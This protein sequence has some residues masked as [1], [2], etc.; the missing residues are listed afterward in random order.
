MFLVLGIVLLLVGSW[1]LFTWMRTRQNEAPRWLSIGRAGSEAAGWFSGAALMI[2]L[3]FGAQLVSGVVAWLLFWL[4]WLCI[5]AVGTT[6]VA[7]S[8]LEAFQ[9]FESPSFGRF[10]LCRIDTTFQRVRSI[11]QRGRRAIA[12]PG[13]KEVQ[14][15][16]L[17]L[18]R[19]ITAGSVIRGYLLGLILVPVLVAVAF[20]GAMN[21]GAVLERQVL[22]V[23]VGYNALAAV[24]W[25]TVAMFLVLGIVALAVYAKVL[26]IDLDMKR[27]FGMV[28]A[29]TGYG[30][31]AGF[32]AGALLPVVVR[33]MPMTSRTERSAE[34][35]LSPEL[36][37]DVPAAGA[38]AGYGLGI[39]VASTELCANARNL[40]LRRM[41]AP[42][43][44]MGALSALTSFDLGPRSII[45]H[46][47]ASAAPPAVDTCTEAAVDSHLE[48]SAWVMQALRVC[49]DHDAVVD[50]PAALWITGL[51]IVATTLTAFVKDF[52]RQYTLTPKAGVDQFVENRS[53]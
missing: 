6:L 10:V 7:A 40:V 34:A 16:F 27:V 26:L 5:A 42:V 23:V 49:G 13:E 9:A 15:G 47:L 29:W 43:L 38:V 14:L 28:A 36:L 11:V 25:M 17:A 39:M 20:A 41:L 45:Q 35:A 1:R 32:I 31:A 30:T 44:L 33:I 21:S 48:D 3:H 8:V 19:L 12:P 24:S 53:I 18:E 46:L 22:G 37:I 50:D 2:I 4:F 51:L 52:R